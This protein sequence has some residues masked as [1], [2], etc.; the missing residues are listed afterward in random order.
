MLA[1]Q[2]FGYDVGGHNF[3]IQEQPMHESLNFFH[4]GIDQLAKPT[5][6][7][8]SADSPVTSPVNSPEKLPNQTDVTFSDVGTNLED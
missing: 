1:Q 8:D 2:A 3:H 5:N 7:V 4:A 6:P